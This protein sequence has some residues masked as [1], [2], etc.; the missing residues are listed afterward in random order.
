MTCFNED[1]SIHE[2]LQVLE[3]LKSM[4]EHN[5]IDSVLQQKMHQQQQIFYKQLPTSTIPMF[6]Q[7]E[8]PDDSKQRG[9]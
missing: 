7:V 1:T 9:N 4:A 8:K 5:I 6:Q 2:S 3:D